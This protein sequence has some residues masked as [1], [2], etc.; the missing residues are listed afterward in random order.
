MLPRWPRESAADVAH[1]PVRGSFFA[2]FRDL[3]AASFFHVWEG[4]A[5]G[6]KMAINRRQTSSRN[7]A[8]SP[9]LPICPVNRT[10][11]TVAIL[12]RA[13]AP[14]T[15]CNTNACHITVSPRPAAPLLIAVPV[16]EIGCQH[17][18]AEQTH[19]RHEQDYHGQIQ[20]LGGRAIGCGSRPAHGAL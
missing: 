4:T 16:A 9:C 20:R 18:A 5:M 12:P 6:I 11:A 2:P 15:I 17:D 19:R 7:S 14:Q 10:Q 3:R 13:I 1:A 8:S